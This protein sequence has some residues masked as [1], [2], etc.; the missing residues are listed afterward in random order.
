M[1]MAFNISSSFNLV[2]CFI[3]TPISYIVFLQNTSWIRKP[4]DILGAGSVCTSCTLPL[5]PPLWNDWVS[6]CKQLLQVYVK[7]EL[8][9]LLYE[10]PSAKADKFRSN[11]KTIRHF[12]KK[13]ASSYKSSRLESSLSDQRIRNISVAHCGTYSPIFPRGHAPN[14]SCAWY[15]SWAG[16]LGWG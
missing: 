7:Q 6:M 14:L 9:F 1:F 5:D 2:S 15:T 8:K 12:L 4:Q 10:E 11:L 13:K 16:S 3:S